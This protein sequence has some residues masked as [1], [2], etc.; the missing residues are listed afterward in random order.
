M[1][2]F[3]FQEIEFVPA[4]IRPPEPLPMVFEPMPS[5]LIEHYQPSPSEVELGVTSTTA[6]RIITLLCNN[7]ELKHLNGFLYL[8]GLDL[9][10]Q[11]E[12]A[13]QLCTRLIRDMHC[14]T[15]E[16]VLTWFEEIP[17]AEALY[18]VYIGTQAKLLERLIKGELDFIDYK[19][20]IAT[21]ELF[22]QKYFLVDIPLSEMSPEW[23]DFA[24]E[25]EHGS[26]IRRVCQEMADRLH[27]E[28]DIRL[29]PYY[30]TKYDDQVVSIMSV[31]IANIYELCHNNPSLYIEFMKRLIAEMEKTSTYHSQGDSKYL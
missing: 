6:A 29:R 9:R 14:Q 5:C 23:H 18:D 10:G 15:W 28:P 19:T 2:P 13:E 17:S 20:Q 7:P 12:E 16:E 22:W 26:Q 3:Q 30:V 24:H 27:R 8:R 25:Q 4:G 31:S 11:P 21:L 1:K